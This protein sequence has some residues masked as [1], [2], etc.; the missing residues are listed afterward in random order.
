M[1][2]ENPADSSIGINGIACRQILYINHDTGMPWNLA[3]AL[4]HRTFSAADTSRCQR[5][6]NATKS[7]EDRSLTVDARVIGLDVDVGDL[8]VLDN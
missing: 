2:W 4:V 3:V 1:S 7:F 8:A 5:L 6:V